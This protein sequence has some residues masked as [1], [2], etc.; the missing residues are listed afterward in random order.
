MWLYASSRVFGDLR[1]TGACELWEIGDNKQRGEE[2]VYCGELSLE[3]SCLGPRTEQIF[4][5]PEE[6]H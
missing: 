3:F 5:R 4:L 6:S 1:R 2:V